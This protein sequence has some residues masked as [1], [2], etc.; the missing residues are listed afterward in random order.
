MNRQVNLT[1]PQEW[2]EQLQKE[3][4]ARSVK[5]D[6]TI[7]YLDLIRVAIKEKYNLKNPKD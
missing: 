5:E 3:A 6:K 4:R 7:A 2:L 1:I